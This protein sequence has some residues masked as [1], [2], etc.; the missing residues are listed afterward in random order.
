MVD[1]LFI[2]RVKHSLSNG[3]LKKRTE[4][5]I[6]VTT[7]VVYLKS[8]VDGQTPVLGK[9]YFCC[10]LVDKHLRVLNEEQCVP[11]ISYLL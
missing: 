8:L 11:Y 2:D 7:F 9:S 4:G 10:A 6:T 3:E 5:F 1:L